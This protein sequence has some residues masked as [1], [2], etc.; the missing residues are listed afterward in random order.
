MQ[1]R[2]GKI[3][4]LPAHWEEESEICTNNGPGAIKSGPFGSQLLTSEMSGSDVNI[5][6]QEMW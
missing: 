5:Y 3:G 2:S 4:E 6:N 1:K